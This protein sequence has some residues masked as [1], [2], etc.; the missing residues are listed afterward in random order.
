MNLDK[1]F[2][3]LNKKRMF[4]LANQIFKIYSKI[5][6]PSKHIILKLSRHIEPSLLREWVSQRVPHSQKLEISELNGLIDLLDDQKTVTPL[7]TK[8]IA[9]CLSG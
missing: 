4:A 9:V 1:L 7:I 6:K 2:L 5:A 3:K 8:K